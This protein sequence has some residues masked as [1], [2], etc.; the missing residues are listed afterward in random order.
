MLDEA[1][2]RPGTDGV[3]EKNGKKLA[4]TVYTNAGNK[5]RETFINVLQEQWRE[6]GVA[7]TPKTEEFNALLNR[8]QKAR[9]FEMILIGFNWSPDPDQTTMWHTKSYQGGFNNNMYSNP[10]VDKLLEQIVRELDRDKRKP[11][12]KQ[13]DKLIVDD[14]GSPILVFQKVL[15]PV[16]KRVKGLEPNPFNLTHNV[17]S[18]TVG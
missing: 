4:F 11:M 2:W 7:A 9:D 5:V 10:E 12:L 16:N 3:R 18:W 14:A 15:M 8:F 17:E 13:L 1:G 6:I